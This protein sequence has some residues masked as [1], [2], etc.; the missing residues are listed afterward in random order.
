[1]LRDTF[2]RR[3]SDSGNEDSAIGI[4]LLRH[5]HDFWEDVLEE[6][7]HRMKPTARDD[8]N[9]VLYNW[10]NCPPHLELFTFVTI[11][12]CQSGSSNETVFNAV[13]THFSANSVLYHFLIV[14][15]NEHLNNSPVNFVEVNKSPGWQSI[16][17]FRKN[18][19]T[20]GIICG[21]LSFP[22]L[23]LGPVSAANR[24]LLSRLCR[25]ETPPFS[26]GTKWSCGLFVFGVVLCV[27]EFS[28]HTV[29]SGFNNLVND[30]SDD[31]NY[32][33]HQSVWWWK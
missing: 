22:S 23:E 33:E 29:Y 8:D 2:L 16:K 13:G 32:N 21:H 27:C 17:N 30:W 5:K 11:V 9:P 20:T 3:C 25:A 4:C 6:S 31:S 19:Y 12:T 26:W 14:W 24:L 15:R 18:N 28:S 10:D 7:N 1:M